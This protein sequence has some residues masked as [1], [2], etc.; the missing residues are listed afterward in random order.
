MSSQNTA[1]AL[2]PVLKTSAIFSDLSV[3]EFN[4]VSAFLEPR[5]VKEGEIIFKEGEA[6]EE[7]FILVSGKISAWVGQPDGTQRWMFEIKPGDFFGEMSVIANECRSATLTARADTELLILHGIDFYRIIYEHPMIGVKILK[8]IGKV[9]GFW[10]EEVS[11]SLSDL[12]RWGEKA[13]RRAVSDDLTGLY[14]RSFLEDSAKDRFKRG[15]FGPRCVSLLMMDLDRFH[16]VNRRFGVR[17]GDQVFVVIAEIF[18]SVT[19]TDDI[20]ARLSGDEFALFLPDTQPEEARVIA[21][22]I[23][24]TVSSRKIL[25]PKNLGTSDESN[26]GKSP[27]KNDSEQIEILINI[28]IGIASAPVHADNWEKLFLSADNA[29]RRAK[30]KGRNRVEV[31]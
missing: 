11:K 13:R 7:L 25:I 19:R 12:L 15:S 20:C 1:T 27:A 26:Y 4:A 22:R 17:A 10:L 23:R 31:A 3:L 8:A 6:G 2:D 14:N 21:E 16:E 18:R 30:E 24:Q 9:Q 5:R 28:S 29:L